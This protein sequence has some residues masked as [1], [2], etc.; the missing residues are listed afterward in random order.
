MWLARVRSFI[1]RHRAVYW[2]V[3]A[4]L[5]LTVAA[6][7]V[8]RTRQVEHARDAWGTSIEVWVAAADVSPGAELV[9]QQRLVPEAMVPDDAVTG[10]WPA[11]AVARQWVTIGEVV[12]A[13][14]VGAGRL[15][16]LPPGERAVAIAADDS[17]IT[18]VVGDHVDIVAGGVVLAQDGTVVELGPGAAIVAV[19]A[20]AAPAVAA[21]AL[22]HTAV[23][24][25][26]PT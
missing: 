4:G 16:L 22:D 11:G 5:A 15:P 17:T 7:V 12:V 6:V 26:R 18:A 1:A 24:V 10:A 9:A 21:A 20:D 23:I 13:H 2:L 3:V 8:S 25:L 19:A 14:D